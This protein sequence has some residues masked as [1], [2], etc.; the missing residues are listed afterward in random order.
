LILI[1]PGSFEPGLSFGFD[2]VRLGPI[3]RGPREDHEKNPHRGRFRGDWVLDWTVGGDILGVSRVGGRRGIRLH[4]RTRRTRWSRLIAG[5]DAAGSHRSASSRIDAKENADMQRAS[6][7]GACGALAM[8]AI[9]SADLIISEVVDAPLPGGLPKF[10]EITNTGTIEVDL[11]QYSVGIFSNGSNVLGSNALVLDGVLAIGD[12]YVISFENGDEPESSIFFDVYGFDAD[13][14][15]LGTLINGDDA[16]VLFAG[17]ALAG[18]PGDGTVAPVQDVYGVVGVDGTS[19]EWDYTDSYAVRAPTAVVGGGALFDELEWIFGGPGALDA[20]TDPEIVDLILLNTSPGNHDFEIDPADLDADGVLNE[21]D[22]C[23]DLTNPDQA[24][25]DDDGFGDVCEIAE[26][27]QEDLNGN[28]IPDECENPPT[29]VISGVIDGPLPGGLPKAVELHVIE[30]IADLS[31]YGVGV[32]NNGGGSDGQE[33]T[34]TGSALAGDYI[35]VASESVGFEDFFGFVPDFTDNDMA[36]N[37]NDAIEL[38]RDGIV[39][40]V[41]GEIDEDGF[42]TPWEYTDGWS[43]RV[44]ETGPDGTT[45]MLE[46]WSF[47]GV[48]ALDG[49][50]SN[51]TAEVPFPIGTYFFEPD[52]DDIDAD[53]VPNDEDNC[54]ETPN[55]NQEDADDDGVGD[56]CDNC[57]DAENPNQEDQDGDGFGDACDNCPEFENPAQNDCDNDG[58][59]DICEI[60]EGTQFDENNNGVPDDCEVIPPAN[61]FINEIRI[62]ET[63]ADVDEYFELR[64]D[65]F[66]QLGGLAYVVLGDDVADGAGQQDNSGVIEEII[67]LD[68]LFLGLD[69]LFFV[70]QETYTG[71]TF[72]KDLTVELNFENGDN[73]THLLVA[74]FTGFLGQDLDTDDDGTLDVVPWTHELDGVALLVDDAEPPTSTEF[75]YTAETVMPLP[76][77]PTI[78]HAYR[79]VEDGGFGFWIAGRFDKNDPEAMDTPASANPACPEILCPEDLNSDDLVDVSDLLILLGAWGGDGPADIDGSGTVDVQD[80]LLLLGAWGAC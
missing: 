24:D 33:V 4:P 6:W 50:T 66:T 79:C 57:P 75:W 10:V 70:A 23:P 13:N 26:G 52:L 14:L 30:D 78:G 68:S 49:E 28:G 21:D 5:R 67:E 71:P 25:C 65:P 45:F 32:A 3:A 39:I 19:E 11:S 42:G 48:D 27:T 20:P 44:N 80:L 43:Y 47:S 62:D 9:A 29:M 37:G 58:V 73:V 55:P 61:L 15:E 8:S 22:N 56:V 54:P 38:F 51:E 59:G 35:Y 60:A 36:I 34:F 2:L 40:D 77:D 72:D 46:S 18:D 12:S 74:N 76:G 16:I 41:F 17:T 7:I 69:G 63:G 53:G 1:G 64:G 31:I